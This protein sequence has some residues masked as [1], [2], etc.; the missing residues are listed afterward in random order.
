VS[1]GGIAVAIAEMA[2]AS[3]IGAMIDKPQPFGCARSFFG[4]DQGVYIVTVPD[5]ALVPFLDTALVAGVTV[6]PLGRTIKNRLIFER[7]DRDCVVTLDELRAAHEG[8]FPK[9]MGT[10]AALA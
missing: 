5:M 6:E 3:G 2:L 8:F 10:D 1:D 7:P 9:L 4:E